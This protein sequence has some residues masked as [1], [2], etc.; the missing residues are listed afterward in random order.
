MTDP[1]MSIGGIM[2]IEGLI[3]DIYAHMAPVPGEQTQPLVDNGTPTMSLYDAYQQYSGSNYQV[4]ILQERIAEMHR[5]LLD[6]YLTRDDM[7]AQ[8]RDVLDQQDRTQ[9]HEACNDKTILE[10]I[11]ASWGLNR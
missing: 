2:S 1:G 9:T 8:L 10:A 7:L 4:Q 6:A 3:D 11:H 5:Q